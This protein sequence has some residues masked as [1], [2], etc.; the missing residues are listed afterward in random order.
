MTITVSLIVL[1][2][3]ALLF[4]LRLA[5]VRALILADEGNPSQSIEAVDVQ[6]FQNL[7]DPA[8]EEFLHAHLPPRTFRMLR[9]ERQRAA[10]EYIARAAQN[11]LV[12]TRVGE[13]A[14]HSGNPSVAEAGERLVDSATRLR[15]YTLRA[16]LKLYIGLYLPWLNIPTTRIADH[17]ER[18]HRL[19]VLLG[20]RKHSSHGVSAS[21]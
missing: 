1:G 3:L 9:R 4:L 7:L 12:L 16:V 19:V 18:T 21:P 20:C 13:A 14:R 17:Y 6:A 8:E 5:K 10:I 11:A 2:V 15:L